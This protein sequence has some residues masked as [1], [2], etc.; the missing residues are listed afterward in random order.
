MF[1]TIRSIT[2]PDVD[3]PIAVGTVHNG[4]A[5]ISG[6]VGFKP[7]TTEPIAPDI[8]SQTRETLRLIDEALAQAGTNKSRLIVM[9]VYLAEVQRDFGA[10]NKVFAKWIEDHRMARTTVGATLAKPG[11]LIEID[12]IAATD[13]V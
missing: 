2:K 6:H 4:L 3:L 5:Y 8:E 13:E 12:G 1:R 7:G 11:L 9:K 10:M